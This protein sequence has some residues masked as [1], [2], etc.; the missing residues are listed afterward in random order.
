VNKNL[1]E[2]EKQKKLNEKFWDRDVNT[3]TRIL[4]DEI[5]DHEKESNWQEVFMFN[6]GMSKIQEGMLASTLWLFM[7][8]NPSQVNGYRSRN[9]VFYMLAIFGYT[10]IKF[11]TDGCTGK[12]NSK[13]N[14]PKLLLL[15][16]QVIFAVSSAFLLAYAAK[17]NYIKM[18][19]QVYYNNAE[20]KGA[21]KFYMGG[22][23]LDADK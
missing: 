12:C 3:D 22:I 7:I 15:L 21:S 4:L 23:D 5:I 2:I 17:C 6:Q 9:V 14:R 8:M 20:T 18:E 19:D 11:L 13:S 10:L 16:S 1:E